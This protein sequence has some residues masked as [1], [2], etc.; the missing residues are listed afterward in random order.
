[1]LY[2]DN[3]FLQY[4]VSG[5]PFDPFSTDD[6]IYSINGFTIRHPHMFVRSKKKAR[7]G[8]ISLYLALKKPHIHKQRMGDMVIESVQP[9]TMSTSECIDVIM[10]EVIPEIE[11]SINAL[12]PD[13]PARDAMALVPSF[14]DNGKVS[15]ESITKKRK[16]YYLEL[17][18][19][20]PPTDQ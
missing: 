17:K 16:M 13:K 15:I 8:V 20:I 4:I 19:E 18:R 1:M 9:V 3:T 2:L 12:Q 5:D 7:A 6:I 10:F 14:F 11:V